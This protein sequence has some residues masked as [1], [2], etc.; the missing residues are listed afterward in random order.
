MN[1]TSSGT[2]NVLCW[3]KRLL[4]AEDLRRHLTSQREL[5]LLPKTVITPLAAD[6]LRAKGVRIRWQ[7]IETK[8]KTTTGGW[9]ILQESNDANMTAALRS[10]ERD[11]ITLA[12]VHTTPRALAESIVK[13]GHAGAI[14]ATS[15]AALVCCIANKIIGVRAAAVGNVKQAA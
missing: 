3:P 2:S 4:S 8:T 12:A 1:G 5:L 6:E 14:V 15:D 7:A 9:L 13:E 11:G 10:L